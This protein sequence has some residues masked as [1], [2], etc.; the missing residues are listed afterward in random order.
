M[1]ISLI[2]RQKLSANNFKIAWNTHLHLLHWTKVEL[3]SSQNIYSP[4]ITQHYAKLAS[5]TSEKWLMLSHILKIFAEFSPNYNQCIADL[6]F[7]RYKFFGSQN[8]TSVYITHKTSEKI[9]LKA[10]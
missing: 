9:C 7:R 10:A 2:F 6:S 8:E 5:V 1:K 3:I 4:Q